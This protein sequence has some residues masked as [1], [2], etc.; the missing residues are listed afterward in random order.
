MGRKNKAKKKTEAAAAT[1]VQNDEVIDEPQ[2]VEAQKVDE[3]TE[4]TE[5]TTEAV[6]ESKDQV[7]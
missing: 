1:S 2:K 7:P 5:I 3:V 6:E 4:S